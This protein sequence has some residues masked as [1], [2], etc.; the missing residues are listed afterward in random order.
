MSSSVDQVFTGVYDRDVAIELSVEMVVHCAS[1]QRD[2]AG[3]HALFNV[4]TD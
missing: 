3:L 4:E 2:I 1:K